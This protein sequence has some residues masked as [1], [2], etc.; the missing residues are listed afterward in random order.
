MADDGP[1]PISPAA[2]Q[3]MRDFSSYYSHVPYGQGIVKSALAPVMDELDPILDIAPEQWIASMTPH[4]G[5]KLYRFAP[6]L[7]YKS[8]VSAR[9]AALMRAAGDL[10]IPPVSLVVRGLAGRPS[11]G[12]ATAV[13]GVI[14]DKGR[15]FRWWCVDGEMRREVVTMM[16]QLLRRLHGRGIVH[17][18]VN[19]ASFVWNREDG[20]LRLVDFAGARFLHED[21]RLWD[22]QC[23]G[24]E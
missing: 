7:V 6:D 18:S 21:P 1:P 15:R 23:V 5:G 14:M 17:G 2:I 9:E 3:Q 4:T 13:V 10:T 11:P 16:V 12:G 8:Q 19:P 22:D 20:S 24:D